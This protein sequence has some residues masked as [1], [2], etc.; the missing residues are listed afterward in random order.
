MILPAAPVLPVPLSEIN[1]AA[2]KTNVRENNIEAV[3][4][5]GI[6]NKKQDLKTKTEVIITAP[7]EP[8]VSPIDVKPDCST[9]DYSPSVLARRRRDNLH[10][11]Y[12]EAAKKS[13]EVFAR[14]NATLG[15]QVCSY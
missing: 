7:A 13:Q 12:Q 6:I 4:N 10:K 1:R 11:R 14:L 9:P 5:N 3:L 2:E 8:N 15:S